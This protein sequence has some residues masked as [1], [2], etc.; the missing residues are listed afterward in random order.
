MASHDQ[1]VLYCYQKLLKLYPEAYRQEYEA[2]MVYTMEAMLV[3][4][5]TPAAKW[6]FLVRASRDYLV[7]LTRQNVLALEDAVP[8]TP[9]YIQRSSKLGLGLVAPFFIVCTYNC[10]NQYLLH[11]AVP[12]AWLEAKTWIIY[13]IVLPLLAFIIVTTAGTRSLSEYVCKHGQLSSSR[14]IVYDWLLLG[15]PLVLLITLTLL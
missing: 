6:Q 11:Q 9:P 12:Y 4:A 2:E 5:D 13:C 7:S 3:D 14:S 10:I 8:A 15:V 1:S